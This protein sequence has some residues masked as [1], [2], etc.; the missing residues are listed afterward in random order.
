MNTTYN[1][2]EIIQFEDDAVLVARKPAGLAVESRKV[3]ETD[4]ESLLRNYVMQ[5][6]EEIYTVH[7][8]DQRVEGLL[9]FG[10]TREAAAFLSKQLTDG[11]MHK[12]YRA[13]VEGDIKAE[14]EKLTDYLMKNPSTHLAQVVSE[15]KA[16]SMK[17]KNRPK[18]AVLTYQKLSDS[19]VEVSLETGRF[20]QIRAQ[21]SHRGMP[22]QGDVKYGA[23][24]RGQLCLCAVRLTFVHPVKNKEM[25]F[26]TEPSF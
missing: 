14:E 13:K 2:E 26:I 8:L 24:T 3:T 1:I 9:V 22:I 20:H 18:R 4:L 6:G 11:R 21:L 16:K 17:G 5:K 25:T 7:R 19:L 12:I 10:K 23:K 15:Q